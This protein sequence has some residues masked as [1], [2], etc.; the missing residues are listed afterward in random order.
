M[1]KENKVQTLVIVF[2]VIAIVAMS[3][4]FAAFSSSLEI[5]GTAHVSQASWKVAFDSTSYKETEGSLSTNPTFG[6]TSVSYDV[7]LTKPGDFYEFTINVKNSGTFNAKLTNITMSTLSAEQQ[8][9]LKYTITHHDVVYSTT[10]N[11]IDAPD[12]VSKNVEPIKVRVEYIQPEN[13]D[14]LPNDNV[15]VTLGATL[16]YSQA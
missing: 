10:A 14:D 5:N 6:E 3:I 2:L 12:L 16:S 7:T 1:S 8:K 4:G 13:A 9:Y 11:V 15:D